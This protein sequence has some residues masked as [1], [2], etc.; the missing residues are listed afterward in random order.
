DHWLP[1]MGGSGVEVTRDMAHAKEF[2]TVL[3]AERSVEAVAGLKA[4]ARELRMQV[5]QTMRLRFVPEL[6]VHYDDSLDR[7]ERIST[8]LRD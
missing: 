2:V 5:G 1:S 3:Q 8:L 6:H 7:G 4:L